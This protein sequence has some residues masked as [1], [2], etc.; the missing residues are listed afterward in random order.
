M[1]EFLQQAGYVLE[2]LSNI[3]SRSGY[4]GIAY[5]DGDEVEQR[6]ADIISHAFD[7]TVLSTELRQHC[8]DWAS[9]YHLSGARANILRPFKNVLQG[10]VLEIGA[11]CGAITRYLGECGAN[12]LA[13]EGSPRRAAI[14]RSRTRDLDNVTVL[15]EK[16]DQ[17]QCDHQ[18]D[19][20]TLIGVLEYANLFTTGENPA[21]SML[22]RVRSLLKPEGK[23]I[24]AIENQLGLKYFAGAPEDHLG[25]PIVGI[26]G[27]YRKDQPQTFGRKVLAG[28]LEQAGFAAQEFLAPF[29]DYK[30][31]VS[32]ITEEG[33]LNKKFDAAAFAWQSARRDPQLP[34][35]CNFSLELAWPQVFQ[36]GL[37]LDVANSFLIIAAP[38]SQKLIATGELAYHYSVDRIPEYCKETVF[39]LGDGGD[40]CV[41]YRRLDTRNGN[42]DEANGLIRFVFPEADKYVVGRPLSLEFIGIVT[43]D[44]WT[45]D[46]LA[47]FVRRYLLIVGTFFSPANVQECMA[48]P[49]AELPGEL[50]DAVPQ[51]II[52]CEDGNASLIDKEWQLTSPIEVAYLLFRS[53]LLLIN[54]ITR[55]GLPASQ[56]VMTRYQFI[57]GVFEA[58]GLRVQERDYIRYISLEATIQQS[59]TGRAAENY[60]TWGKDQ[61]LPILNL[62]QALAERDEQIASLNQAVTE[63]D[64]QIASLSQ[65]VIERDEAIRTI[66]SMRASKSWRLTA[67]LR[68]VGHLARGNYG[69]AA[70]LVAHGMRQIASRLPQPIVRP[71]RRGRDWLLNVTGILPNSSANFPAIAAIVEERCERTRAPIAVD[72]MC[73]PEPADWP[74]IDV[75][76]VTYNSRCWIEAFVD[77]LLAL[78]YPKDR[79]TIRFVDNSSTDDTE[80]ALRAV[81]PRL[82]AA[83]FAVDVIPQPN[84]G[85][86]AGHNAAIRAGRAPF[87]LVTNIDLTFERDSLRQV[88]AMAVADAPQAAAWELRQKPYEHPKYYDPVTGTTNWNA[89]ACVLLRRSA[90]E[91]I[92]GYDETLFMYGED[93]ELSYRLRRAGYLLR[94]C[95]AAV[96]WHYS[97]ESR[98]QVKPLQ[99]IGSTFGNLYLRLKFGRLADIVVV[100][101]LAL[102]LLLSPEVFPGSRRRVARSLLRLIAVAPKALLSRRSSQAHFPFRTWDYE[103]IRDGAFVEQR[104]LPVEQPLVSIITRTYRGR[105]LYLRQALMSGAHQT[106]SNL[107]HIVVEDGGDTM[108]GLCEEVAQAT[109]RTIRFI[110]NDK[111]GR[112]KAGN[113]GLAAARGRWCVFLDDDDLLFAEH[114][115]VLAN[116]LLTDPEAVASYSLAWEVITDTTSLAEGRYVEVSHNL[117]LVLCQPFDFDVLQHHNY[118]AI[119]SVLFERQL[120]EHRGGFYEDMDALEDWT[121]WIRYA[122]NHRFVYVPKVTSLFRTPADPAKAQERSVAFERAYPLAL[123]RVQAWIAQYRRASPAARQPTWLQTRS[124]RPEEHGESI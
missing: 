22:K 48:S 76:V 47:R 71:L 11:G 86:G 72:P 61:P 123:S 35:Y 73:P 8:T 24:I 88:V 55:F 7:V 58:S 49:Y 12:V 87:C 43:N 115:E 95:P 107:E 4:G 91:A 80:S 111:P 46:Q 56:A 82:Q 29:P 54:S 37:G 99:Y 67:P 105:D 27:R 39:T 69:L 18:F 77:S 5:S 100:P 50:F 62:S 109:G 10:D 23:L 92:D 33:F 40:I 104:S 120:F 13:L 79:V 64:E 117:P 30:L 90:V 31:P 60:L 97:Y 26:E 14:A 36:N 2:P 57:D 98:D 38:N 15:A 52:I 19:V 44:G 16:F 28:M 65:A 74:A 84:L 101:M 41:G 25:Q 42:A 121:L 96:V 66:R 20:I 85:Y 122:W 114:I 63:R 21:L 17:F 118:F 1:K 81:A 83:G 59:I 70:R 9:L 103:L 93:V 89:H 106:W 113:A 53:L 124:P 119:Q 78:D 45:F 112:S 68:F 51:N 6:I 102:R 34:T 32:I 3:W 108:R 75:G 116:A 94:Y 110:A